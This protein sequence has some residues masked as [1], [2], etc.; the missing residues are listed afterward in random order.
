M[1]E[2]SDRVPAPDVAKRDSN[3]HQVRRF[4][5]QLAAP[6][7]FSPDLWRR[8]VANVSCVILNFH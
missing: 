7:G 1:E 5:L 4:C 8:H 6:L 2:P 3:L